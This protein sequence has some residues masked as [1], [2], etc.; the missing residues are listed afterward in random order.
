MKQG[1]IK[2]LVYFYLDQKLTKSEILFQYIEND[3][4][5]DK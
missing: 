2:V 1:L 3:K 5:T 4:P